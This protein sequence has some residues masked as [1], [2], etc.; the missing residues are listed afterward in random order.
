MTETECLQ[1]NFGSVD[2]MHAFSMVFVER[3]NCMQ[4]PAHDF[5]FSDR[6]KLG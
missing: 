3:Q 4:Q 2:T 1:V 6:L 5:F